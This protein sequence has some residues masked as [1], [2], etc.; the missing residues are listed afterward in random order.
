MQIEIGSF[1]L[2]PHNDLCW[3]VFEWRM[4]EPN[5]HHRRNGAVPE[6]K[7]C[8]LG[9]YPSTLALALQEVYELSM[10]KDERGVYGISLPR[11]MVSVRSGWWGD[12]RKEDR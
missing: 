9:K 7:W 2:K 3:E 6:E 5:A 1:M 8:S 11:T 4:T 10:K 12:E